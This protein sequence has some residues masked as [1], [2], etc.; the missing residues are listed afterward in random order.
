[1]E[2]LLPLDEA[3]IAA[4]VTSLALPGLDAAALAAPLLRHTGGNPLFLLETRK[5]LVLAGGTG[6]GALPQPTTVGVLIERRL[7][8]LSQTAL[9]LAR[10]AALA[11]VDFSISLAETVLH[12]PALE[13]VEAWLELQQA[14]V[15]AGERFA[16]DLVLDAVNRAVPETI[17]RH[18]HA[19]I[20]EVLAA[21]G[22]EPA[23]LAEHW[24]AAQRWANAADS[25]AQAAARAQRWAPGRRPVS[26]AAW[27]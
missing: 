25:F 17:A 23:R 1:V 14:Q 22:S 18:V 5:D 8:A 26:V 12:K 7:R 4:L 13:L 27:R 3:G 16:H 21:G 6:P 24:R 15:L 10:V 19:A 20:A 2:S 9:A 11:G